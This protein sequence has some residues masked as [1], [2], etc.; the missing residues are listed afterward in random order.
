MISLTILYPKTADSQFDMRYYLD[1]HVPLVRQRLTSLGLVQISLEEGLTGN[2]PDAPAQY[3][4]IGHMYFGSSND[5]QE[6]LA[7]HG[8]EL[9]DDIPNFTN[10]QPL[11][12]V[13]Q[14]L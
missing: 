8:Q 9:I 4:V 6:A 12:Q 13:S 10:V 11:M 7:T 2:T 3:A 14:V 5:L 1:K